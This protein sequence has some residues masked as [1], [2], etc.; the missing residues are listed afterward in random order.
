M[1][2]LAV[3]PDLLNQTRMQHTDACKNSKWIQVQTARGHKYKHLHGY[4][5]VY[6]FLLAFTLRTH[7]HKKHI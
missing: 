6:A 7:H 4:I 2:V 3:A 1:H 5:E